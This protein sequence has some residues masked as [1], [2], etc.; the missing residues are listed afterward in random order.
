MMSFCLISDGAEADVDLEK[1]K[2]S[3]TSSKAAPKSLRPCATD[4]YLLFQVKQ[5][6]TDLL[7]KNSILI[8]WFYAPVIVICFT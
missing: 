6:N 2:S 3:S 5:E 4:A 7:K 1:L 8:S